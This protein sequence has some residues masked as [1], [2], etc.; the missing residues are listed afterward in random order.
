[1]EHKLNL[2]IHNQIIYNNEFCTGLMMLEKVMRK[3]TDQYVT[4]E[5]TPTCQ[6]KRMLN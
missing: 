6:Q 5:A 3:L 2:P 1:M 4:I